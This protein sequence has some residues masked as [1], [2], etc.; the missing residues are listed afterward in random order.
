MQLKKVCVL[1]FMKVDVLQ[2][3]V[4]VLEE[5]CERLPCS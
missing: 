2:V 3:L 1:L 5:I 4:L